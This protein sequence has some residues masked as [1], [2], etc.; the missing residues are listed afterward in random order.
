MSPTLVESAA[1]LGIA[2]SA[3]QAAKLLRVLDELDDWNQRMNLTA[4]RERSAQITKHLLD[5]LSI[6]SFL[7]GSRVCDIGTGAGFPGIPLAIV[8]PERQF[9][10]V[11]STAKKLKFIDHVAQLLELRNIVTVHTRA[12]AFRPDERFD[13]VVSRAVGPVEQFVKWAGHLAVGGGRL[14]AMKGKFPEDEVKK[15]PNG[16]KLAAIHRLDVPG[17]DEER[18]LV[19]ICRSHDRV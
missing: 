5:S 13:I 12:E 3:D 18:H 2:L 19:E 17:L 6:Q 14:L 4:I 15:L 8:N 7:R 1:K 11:D 9:T 16:W 10:L